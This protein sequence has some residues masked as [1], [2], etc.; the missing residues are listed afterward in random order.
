[1]NVGMS[2]SWTAARWACISWSSPGLRAGSRLVRNLLLACAVL[3][4]GPALAEPLD[5][6]TVESVGNWLTRYYQSPQPKLVS[7]A[8]LVLS[9]EGVFKREEVTPPTFGFLAGVFAKNKAITPSLI[10]DL[11]ALPEDEQKILILGI[12]YS[13]R[14][15]TKK[16][17]EGLLVTMPQHKANIE[18]LLQ[19]QQVLLTQISLEQGPWIIDALWANFM[20]TGDSEPVKR[21]ITA[22][23]WVNEPPDSPKFLVGRSARW[24]L[25]SYAAQ[26]PRVL[27]ICRQQAKVQPPEVATLLKEAIASA[28]KQRIKPAA[29]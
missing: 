25:T 5:F 27:A 20:A 26:H 7:K 1:M 3:P 9:K 15:D 4:F 18:S 11:T 6:S 12:W 13:G 24:S 14:P 28:E 10:K 23:P 2:M 17:L 29:P 19:G 8:I 21:V 16:L 22:L